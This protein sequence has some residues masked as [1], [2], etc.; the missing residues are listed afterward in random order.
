[1]IDFATEAGSPSTSLD[2]ALSLLTAA[3]S[4]LGG[5]DFGIHHGDLQLISG[6]GSIL[7]HGLPCA[8]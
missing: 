1:M 3:M 5:W 8:G 2:T 4:A 7:P 6:H